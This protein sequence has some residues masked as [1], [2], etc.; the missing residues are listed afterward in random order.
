MKILHTS[1]WHLGRS[2]HRRKRHDEFAAFLDWLTKTIT[3]EKV[4]ILL[5]AGDVF[6]TTIPGN[7]SQELYYQ[8]LNKASNTCCRH[9]IVIGGNHDSPSFLNA[10][11][12]VLRALSVY[13]V[14]SATD[15][16][17]DEVIVL[18]NNEQKPEA[19]IC[20]V[21]YLRDRDI[22]TVD[23]GEN[24]E[25][26]LKK[27]T[28]GLKQHYTAVCEI[29]EAKQKELGEI[30]IVAMGHLF[31]DGGQIVDED[32]V[33]DLYVGNLAH[34]KEDTFKSCIDYLALG[35]LHVPQRVGKA[36]YMR[37]SGAPIPMG[38]GEAKQEKK[39]VVI[40]FD[41]KTPEISELI[42]P[43]FQQ[44]E[45]I[46]GNI[47][48]IQNKIQNLKD[49]ASSA[50]LDIEYTGDEIAG[51]LTELLDEAIS[52]TNLEILRIQNR[53]IRDKVLGSTVSEET[54]DDL[55]HDEVFERCLDAHDVTKTERPQL[56]ESYQIITQ[57]MQENDQYENS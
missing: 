53:R 48:D 30:P 8:F 17:E 5:V 32:G 11:K 20:A 31:T 54:L 25:D 29:A 27:L 21:P 57:Q 1:D 7:R 24:H 26:K 35:H 45:K 44:L 38:F 46:T 9:I 49:T 37:Y 51:N 33:R 19:I 42:I 16:I 50:W 13:V 40:E 47:T 43:M 14:G 34:I 3:A 15:N 2:L 28:N 10:P 36:E 41:G 56:I 12:E 22:R 52:E 18:H 23:A 39:V 6:D 55:D 4:D